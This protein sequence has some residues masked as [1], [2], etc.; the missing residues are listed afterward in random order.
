MELLLTLEK[1]KNWL[2]KVNV[3]GIIFDPKKLKFIPI[4]L[5]EFPDVNAIRI[6]MSEYEEK[7][8][9]LFQIGLIALLEACLGEKIA[10]TQINYVDI[11]SYPESPE[12]YQMSEEFI[13]LEDYI[14]YRRDQIRCN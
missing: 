9:E 7:R 5:V 6:Y 14:E 10:A 2:I 12:E 8:E 13:L 1:L 11:K 3:A 4:E